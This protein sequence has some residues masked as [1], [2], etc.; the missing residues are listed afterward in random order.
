MNENL[1]A[2]ERDKR[3]AAV[4]AD[5]L[6]HPGFQAAL[7]DVSREAKAARGVIFNDAAGDKEHSFARGSLAVLRNIVLAVYWRANK[8]VPPNVAALFE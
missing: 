7:K 4:A 5:L 1:S 6:E 8:E 3:E 2:E